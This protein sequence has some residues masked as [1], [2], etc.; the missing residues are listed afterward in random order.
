[1]V[2]NL[3]PVGAQNCNVSSG[4]AGTFLSVLTTVSQGNKEQRIIID[5]LG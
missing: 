2:T 3:R 4:T 5:Q 1:M